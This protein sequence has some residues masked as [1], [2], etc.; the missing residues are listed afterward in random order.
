MSQSSTAAGQSKLIRRLQGM[1]G[2][3]V[4]IDVHKRSYALAFFCPGKGILGQ[5]T[6]PAH[7]PALVRLLQPL[8]RGLGLCLYEAGPTGYSLVR[9]L[10][11][12]GLPA[13]VVSPGSIPRTANQ[14]SKTD[15][16]DACRLARYGAEGLLGYVR[17]PTEQ[18][19]AERQLLRH[20]A[21]ARG[22]LTRVKNRIKM[23][24]LYNGLP[25]P[26]GLAQW[27]R[28]GVAALKEMAVESMLRME[29]DLL[30][31]AYEF[32]KAQLARYEAA[33]RRLARS[34]RHGDACRRLRTI[35]GVGLL[36]AMTALVELGDPQRFG[37]DKQVA[38]YAGLSP[39]L[40]Q[41]GQS[42]RS[43]GLTSSG[44]RHLRHVL[45]EAAWRWVARDAWARQRYG[46]LRHR[47]G[48]AQKAIAAT[49]RKLAVIIWRMLIE[50]TTYRPDETRSG[51]GPGARV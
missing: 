29:L 38:K 19:D 41:S 1:D 50:G 3:F 2:L 10:R 30:L 20:R 47:T 6:M 27:S 11:A 32:A 28:A 23:F 43:V 5:M 8:R 24:L 35:P 33:V 21:R 14:D 17:V 13:Q 37:R 16:I 9:A 48:C 46:H 18:G 44:N 51:A 26:E 25:E 15:P 45:I 22:D 34:P 40:Q 12:A 39:R 31:G 4:G 42:R 36:T 49:A 7:V